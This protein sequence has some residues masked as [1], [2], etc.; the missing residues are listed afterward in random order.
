MAEGGLLYW[1]VQKIKYAGP[2]VDYSDILRPLP[3]PP[4]GM[5][6][7]KDETTGE[8]SVLKKEDAQE[9][10]S[11]VANHPSP[12]KDSNESKIF[13]T[14]ESKI[15]REVKETSSS[16]SDD[17]KEVEVEVEVNYIE[18]MVLPCDTFQGI[19]LNYKISPTKLRQTNNFSGSN[20]SLA[21]KKLKIPIDGKNVLKI[22]T[23]DQNSKVFKIHSLIN[24]F[25][26]MSNSEARSYLEISDWKLNDARQEA[27]EDREWE[28][29]SL[30][31]TRKRLQNYKID[32][33]L[34]VHVGIPIIASID[35]ETFHDNSLQ[36]QE[37]EMRP[38][39]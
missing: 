30:D 11:N 8:W 26:D 32:R 6:W 28:S 4:K 35:D 17:N 27:K 23:Q 25:P 38:L 1:K 31:F 18:H 29:K 19:C 9:A 37:L 10:V 12:M 22:K 39:L 16:S 7:K 14:N 21:P 15:K 3:D 24:E 34:D 36:L 2:V 13:G 20:L 33:D 5:E